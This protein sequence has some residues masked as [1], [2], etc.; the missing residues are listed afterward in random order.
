MII[1]LR[2]AKPEGRALKVCGGNGRVYLR[3]KRDRKYIESSFA[4]SNVVSVI[5]NWVRG[6]S[7]NVAIRYL[8]ERLYFCERAIGCQSY[9]KEN[10]GGFCFRLVQSGCPSGGQ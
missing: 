1:L 5:A 7:F 10:N 4:E 2:Y 3:C 6:E 9:T 8:D